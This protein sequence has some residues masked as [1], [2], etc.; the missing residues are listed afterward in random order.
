MRNR[1][2]SATAVRYSTQFPVFEADAMAAL[3]EREPLG[4]DTVPDLIL[5]NFKGADFMGHRFGPGSPEL[6]ATLAEMDR[7]LARMLK[8]LQ[9]RVGDNYLLAVTADHGMPSE[10]LS[11]E[12]RHFAPAI[13]DFLHERFDAAGKQL[14]T[15]YESENGQIFVD[16][17]RLSALGLTLRELARFLES[18]PF[19]FAVFTIDD[20]RRAANA[21]RG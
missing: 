15:T 19:V 11:P 14:I 7:Q 17:E 9:A 5:M 3:I 18:Q 21:R 4:S 20:I 16:E 6:R 12:H 8:A 10:P 2:D 13:V 1:I